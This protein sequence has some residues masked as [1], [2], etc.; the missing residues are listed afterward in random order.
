MKKIFAFALLLSTIALNDGMAVKLP[1]FFYTLTISGPTYLSA[2]QSGTLQLLKDGVIPSQS[3]YYVWRMSINNG[4]P[5][6]I[7]QGQ[8]VSSIG[9]VASNPT[10]EYETYTANIYIVSPG[11]EVIGAGSASIDVYQ[12]GCSDY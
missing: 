8:D 6:I 5:F 9:I 10:S 4:T 2:C 11:R 3:Y 1:A 7:D 12:T